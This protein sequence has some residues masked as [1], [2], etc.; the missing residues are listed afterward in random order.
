MDITQIVI[1]V[2]LLAVSTVIVVLGVYLVRLVKDITQT[3][4]K[5]NQIL[6]DTHSIT[7][8]I[9]KPLNS[10]S[11]FVMGFKNGVN[12]FNSFFKKEDK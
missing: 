3:V 6:D 8:S 5:T 4:Q 12:V 7:T 10:V 11:E 9:R 2:S 1:V